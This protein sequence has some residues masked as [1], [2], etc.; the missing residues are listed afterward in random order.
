MLVLIVAIE[1]GGKFFYIGICIEF[2]AMLTRVF[3]ISFGFLWGCLLF[4]FAK[5]SLRKYVILYVVA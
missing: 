1:E 4:P 5:Y 3:L 2:A